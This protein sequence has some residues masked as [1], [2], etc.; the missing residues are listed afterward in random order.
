MK[1]LAFLYM[2][3]ELSTGKWYVG[4][5]TA[6]GCHPNDG[7]ICSSKVIKPM[8]LENSNNWERIVLAIGE[9]DYIVN[10]ESLYLNSLDAKNDVN[11]YNMHNGDGKFSVSGKKVGPQSKQHKE[12]LSVSKKGR[13]AWNKGLTKQLDVRVQKNAT[14]ISK[15][16]K[17][18]PGHMQTEETKLKIALTEKQTKSRNICNMMQVSDVVDVV[19]VI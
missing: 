4:C 3:I 17:G 14:G 9:V 10:L 15:S 19:D 18:K 11:S 1:T 2:W 16:K 12:K 6:K 5:R 13:I 7:Y 8:I